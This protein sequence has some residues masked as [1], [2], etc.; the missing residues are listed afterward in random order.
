M[1]AYH[2]LEVPR[3]INRSRA[4]VVLLSEA[5]VAS[6]WVIREVDAAV[7]AS[8]PVFPVALPGF[9]GVDSLSEDWR[10]LL[11]RAQVRADGDLEA[12]VASIRQ[13][14][15]GPGPSSAVAVGLTP[16]PAQPDPY[17]VPDVSAVPQPLR[18]ASVA[19]RG[20]VGQ[21]R[22][23][24]VSEL[25]RAW[26]QV[27]P[28]A[29]RGWSYLLAET[30]FG[31]TRIVQEFYRGLAAAQPEPPFWPADIV[32]ASTSGHGALRESRKRVAPLDL[33]PADGARADYLWLGHVV[34]EGHGGRVDV[35]LVHLAEDLGRAL[36][37]AAAAEPDGTGARMVTRAL[38]N[39]PIPGT[40]TRVAVTELLHRGA[41]VDGQPVSPG[42]VEAFWQGARALWADPDLAIPAVIVVEDGHFAGQETTSA[43]ESLATSTGLPF[44]IVVCAQESQ[45]GSQT[46][47][48]TGPA[49]VRGAPSVNSSTR[50]CP[51]SL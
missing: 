1:A 2:A 28:P 46:A 39:A 43:L 18:V 42:S 12:V 22:H 21:D 25:L 24:E 50:T 51:R 5:A 26:E 31:K 8:V 19:A 36:G 27:R 40:D 23:E 32:D 30:G 15:M 41:P 11:K 13:G 45:L 10:F 7:S 9:R 20:F 47:T 35:G 6:E 34:D 49:V 48:G 16:G 29:P 17:R 44:L 14:L 3:A 4:L 33:T 38:D 37:L